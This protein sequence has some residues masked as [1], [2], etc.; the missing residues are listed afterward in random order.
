MNESTPLSHF[1]KPPLQQI[2]RQMMGKIEDTPK[3][4]IH[5]RSILLNIVK[6][7]TSY[8]LFLHFGRKDAKKSCDLLILGHNTG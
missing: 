5:L 2:F 3:I 6:I 8:A 7:E 4:T 1:F